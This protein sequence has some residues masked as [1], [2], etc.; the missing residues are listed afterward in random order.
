[1]TREET[2]TKIVEAAF[3]TLAESG[4][5]GTTMKDIATRAGLATG[6][7]HYYFENKDDL[8][9]AALERACPM[10]DLDLEGMPGLDQARLG[11]EAERQ[12]QVWNKD[13]YKLIFDM[14]GTGMH[15]ARM[16]EQIRLFLNSR[17]D[18]VTGVSRAVAAESASPPKAS[19]D[20]VGGAIWGAFLGIAL[21]RL[22]DPD[23]DGDAALGALE[24]MAINMAAE[25]AAGAAAAKGR[26]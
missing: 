19:P 11:F 25:P 14:V 21:Q 3:R 20:A 6:L 16:A 22:I 2:Q 18:V 12:W 24:E 4:Y 23:F 13:A 8:M 1:M 26:S 15:N 7:A 10:A 9:L 5:H 17:R